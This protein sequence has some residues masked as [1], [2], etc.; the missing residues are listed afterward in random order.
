MQSGIIL[1]HAAMVEGMIRRISA[2]R[3]QTPRTIAPGGLCH[4][5]AEEVP[6]IQV[7]DKTPILKW[8]KMMYELN[9]PYV[10]AG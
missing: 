3:P 8:L 5:M 4:V 6:A 7:A 9:A 10:T 2:E 1:G